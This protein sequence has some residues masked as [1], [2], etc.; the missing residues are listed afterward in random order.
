MTHKQLYIISPQ[1]SHLTA[2][3]SGFLCKSSHPAAL[4]T[5]CCNKFDAERQFLPLPG[6]D[7]MWL[8]AQEGGVYGI[9]SSVAGN[10]WR[11]SYELLCVFKCRNHKRF[12]ISMVLC[13]WGVQSWAHLWRI[14]NSKA[15]ITSIWLQS[16]A[17][18]L[19]LLLLLLP[20]CHQWGHCHG[21]WDPQPY[22]W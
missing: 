9:S 21:N 2:S 6:Q 11:V 10:M 19:R 20:E 3:V 5:P 15:F 14:W 18:L 12:H 1:M 16:S 22:G 13:Q 8:T 7:H 4:Y 17:H